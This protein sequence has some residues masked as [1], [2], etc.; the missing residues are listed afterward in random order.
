MESADEQYYCAKLTYFGGQKYILNTLK[1]DCF[2]ECDQT[3]EATVYFTQNDYSPQQ[4]L[5][6]KHLYCVDTGCIYSLSVDT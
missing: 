3:Q 2:V 5:T 4:T 1:G 6:M